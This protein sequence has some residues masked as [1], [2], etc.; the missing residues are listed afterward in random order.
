MGVQLRPL[1]RLL[2]VDLAQD[3]FGPRRG[4]Q[5][6]QQT[7]DQ[8]LSFEIQCGVEQ[9]LGRRVRG[10]VDPHPEAH[11][12]AHVAQ[13]GEL[14]SAAPADPGRLGGVPEEWP[15]HRGVIGDPVFRDAQPVRYH[16]VV[17]QGDRIHPSW[18]D[19]TGR[20]VALA[21]AMK[22][23]RL[24][25]HALAQIR[26][27]GGVATADL[28]RQAIEL[29]RVG[30]HGRD[31]VVQPTDEGIQVESQ[32]HPAVNPDLVS[33][34]FELRIVA[35]GAGDPG[36][37]T[38][39]ASF[40]DDRLGPADRQGVGVELGVGGLG[41]ESV[42]DHVLVGT[43]QLVALRFFKVEEDVV[44][45]QRR[46]LGRP[47]IL[48]PLLLGPALVQVHDLVLGILGLRDRNAQEGEQPS[49]Q[50]QEAKQQRLHRC[51]LIRVA[52]Y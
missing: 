19:V 17:D 33:L 34:V 22:I 23:G 39:P 10:Q 30:D 27:A 42:P 52:G 40:G 50:H 26:L 2:L 14:L 46:T 31:G 47:V 8:D 48:L 21:D 49:G 15:L 45:Q 32:I 4:G 38:F 28:V 5:F 16:L 51:L 3:V 24:A 18:T 43:E 13:Q 29:L 25:F 11:G 36:P 41:D 7:L 9:A 35:R 1:G 20:H 44:G 12:R 6:S 37:L